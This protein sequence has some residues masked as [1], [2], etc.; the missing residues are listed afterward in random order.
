MLIFALL[1]I[2]AL[3]LSFFSPSNAEMLIEKKLEEI[4]VTATK[5]EK[6]LDRIPA[7]VD[8]ITRERID[9][10]PYIKIDDILRTIAH[11]NVV[12]TLGIYTLVPTVTLRGLSDEQARTLVLLDGIPLNKA[13]TG[14]VNFNRINVEEIERVEIFKGP[15]S[16]IYG[17]NAMGGVIHI[18]TKKP[19]KP[20][21]GFIQGFSGSFGTY[22]GDL[23]LSGK[24]KKVFYRITARNLNSDGYISVPP[25]RRT[26][27]TVKR[28]AIE[29]AGTLLV[30][31][32]PTDENT[33][34]F[35][36][37]TYDDKRGEGRKIRHVRGIHRDFDTTSYAINYKGQIQNFTIRGNA[38]YTNENY[39][40][41]SE[42]IRRG[43]Y[44]RFDVD[45]ERIDSGIDLSFSFGVGKSSTLTV[46]GD[47][48]NGSVDGKDIYITS[49]DLTLNKGKIRL[50]GTWVQHEVPFSEGKLNFLMGIRYDHA[51]F[52]D[53]EF[54]STLSEF[55]AYSGKIRSNTWDAI[56]PRF[57]VKY[58]FHPALSGYFSY[59]RGFRAS[60][61]DDLCRTGIM[62]GLYKEANPDLKPE[63]IDTYE[64][65][66][67]WRSNEKFK[68]SGSLYYSLGKDFLYYVPTGRVLS[69][70]ALYRRENVGEVESKGLEASSSY[71]PHK[72]LSFSLNYTLSY[73]EIK[74][75][76]KRPDM[77]GKELTRT[78]RYQIKGNITYLGGP[79]A[80]SL[81][82][83]Y[84]SYQWI[85]TNEIT[86]TMKRLGGYFVLDA[87][88]WKNFGKTVQASVDF[89]NIFDKKYMESAD[90][91]SPGFT[92]I[93]RLKY[94]F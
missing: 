11:V 91:R 2:G 72:N 67:D 23:L 24:K 74:E 48:R 33:L 92:V 15:A 27:D 64:I 77:E 86:Q 76:K 49:P 38:F 17:N 60:I 79:L 25:Y 59:G 45:S 66:F 43:S 18:I 32:E 75:F 62:W 42:T 52:Y 7:R 57:S 82:P 61:L 65:G 10:T 41:V 68:L 84:K 46:G 6:P 83:A 78:P 36:A 16:S 19:D 8:V 39:R 81:L 14:N 29:N 50:V 26:A 55:K 51:H 63:K 69:G 9:E 54:F 73:A 3:S 70:R 53:G 30:G 22:G 12:R 20:F 13:D 80:I 1:V 21:Y 34:T 37:E 31:Y 47:L 44:V 94:S 56:S 5:I 93:G 89:M 4:V 87:R 58:H 40:R 71:N 35:R 85:Y 88:V 28:F 90:E